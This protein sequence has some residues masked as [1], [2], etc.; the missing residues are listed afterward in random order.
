MKQQMPQ[1]RLRRQKNLLPRKEQKKQVKLL[2]KRRNPSAV[3][4]ILAEYIIAY[5]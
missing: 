2:F 1:K 5:L 3:D 4:E